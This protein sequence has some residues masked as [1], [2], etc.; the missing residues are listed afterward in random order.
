MPED[1]KIPEWLDELCDR[2]EGAWGTDKRITIEFVM[3]NLSAQKRPVALKALLE[4]EYELRSKAGDTPTA[5]ELA[6]RFPDNPDVVETI[7]QNPHPADSLAGRETVPPKQMPFDSDSVPASSTQRLPRQLGR[8]RIIRKLGQGAMGSVFLAHDEQLDRQVA[9]KIPRGDLQR[10]QELRTRF[11]REAQ[12]AAALHH[13]NICPIHDIGEFEGIHYI[14]MGYIEGFPLTKYAIAESG[15]SEQRI[16]ELVL[17]LAKALAVAHE[18]GFIHRDLKP[19]NVMVDLNEEP[20][21]LDFG[22]ARRIDRDEDIRVTQ[23]GTTIGSPAYMSPEQ[24]DGDQD[25]VGRHSDIYSLG[26]ILYELLAGR[27][28]FDGSMASVMGQIMTKEPDKPSDYR[29]DLT[30]RLEKICLRM[31]AKEASQRHPSMHAVAAALQEYL[32]KYGSSPATSDAE[33]ATTDQARTGD[34]RKQQ[35]VKLIKSGDYGQAE[36][37]MIALSGETDESLLVAAVWAAAELPKLRRTRE[38]VRAGRQE[39][40]STASRLMKSHDYEQAV[41]LLEEYPYDLRTPKMQELLE[42][43]EGMANEVK[44]LRNEIKAARNRGDNPALLS[45]VRQL[46]ELKP[47]D[48]RAKEL[49]EQLTRK[50]VGPISRA[51]GKKPP[52]FIDRMSTGIQWALLSFL[53]LTACFYPA[54]RWAEGFLNRPSIPVP[55]IQNSDQVTDNGGDSAVVIADDAAEAPSPPAAEQS[56]PT[57]NAGWVSLLDDNF[58]DHW[59][60]YTGGPVRA[61]WN[62][63]N[64]ELTLRK[65][66]AGDIATKKAYSDFELEFEWKISKGGNSGIIYLSRLGDRVS[67]MSGPEYQILDDVGHLNGK[68]AKTSAGSLYALIAPQDKTLKP[69]GEWNTGRIVRNGDHLEHWLN[70]RRIVEIT[71]HDARWNHLVSDSTFKKWK[72]FAKSARG[73]IVLQDHGDQVSFRNMRVKEPSFPSPVVTSR[74]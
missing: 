4:L 19:A 35:I 60:T 18:S 43:T 33:A 41:R 13:P 56:L 34:H 1:S 31:M 58:S 38:E 27:I 3:E 30:V 40:Y 14:S 49:R 24:V 9:L 39:M 66:G 55:P 59:H 62:F 45:L 2:F 50:S 69:V 11:E 67:Y 70:G 53:V 36:K 32:D 64:G 21:I 51:F 63:E 26:V 10:N 23:T 57:D 8:Y 16:A 71:M 28:P 29:K 72:Q 46:L 52:G 73:H 65:K 54:Y 5:E 12:A 68:V 42:Q 7:L 48:R 44:R 6:G 20:V 74:R 22:L 61:G 37:L 47:A 15:L 25:K 17:K